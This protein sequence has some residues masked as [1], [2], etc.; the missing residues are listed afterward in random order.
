MINE[1][2]YDALEQYDIMSILSTA[3]LYTITAG[4]IIDSNKLMNRI[5]DIECISNL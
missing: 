1:E 2:T 3:V 5:C 4:N